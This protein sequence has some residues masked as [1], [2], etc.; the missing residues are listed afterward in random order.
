MTCVLIEGRNLDKD[1]HT[2]RT[3]GETKD[4]DQGGASISQRT[5]KLASK[6]PDTRRGAGNRLS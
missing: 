5:P 1:T 2:R 6:P 4:E 3:P